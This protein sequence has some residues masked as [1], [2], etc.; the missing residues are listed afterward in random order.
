MD[1]LCLSTADQLFSRSGN[2]D[3]DMES[4]GQ[5]QHLP[6]GMIMSA[7]VVDPEHLWPEALQQKRDAVV[8]I[9]I[10]M[11]DNNGIELLYSSLPE[12]GGDDVFTNI[13][14][15]RCMPPPPSMS[16][17]LPAGN[18]RKVELPWPTSRKVISLVVIRSFSSSAGGKTKSKRIRA[19]QPAPII[20]A[21]LLTRIPGDANKNG[22]I[23]ENDEGW[24]RC[25]QPEGGEGEIVEKNCHFQCENQ[26]SGAKVQEQGGAVGHDKDERAGNKAKSQAPQTDQGFYQQVGRGGHHRDPV[27]ISKK[28]GGGANGGGHGDNE[29]RQGEMEKATASVFCQEAPLFF[30]LP[31]VGQ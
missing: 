24:R 17:R 28:Q 15:G 26:A 8:M 30:L 29:G 6:P 25:W 14:A 4:V 22:G 13:K 10:A 7:A 2:L 12:K 31:S 19:Q 5:R 20:L 18:W 1:D 23:I 27:K 11:G 9:G 16:T 3:L 21:V